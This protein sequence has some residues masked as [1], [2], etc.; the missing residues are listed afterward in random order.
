MHPGHMVVRGKQPRAETDLDSVFARIDADFGAHLGRIQDY[1]RVPSVSGTG[2][3]ID[4]TAAATAG[5]I[6]S[7]GGRAQIVSTP[8]HPVVI[9]S[10][11]GDGP[12]LLRYGMYDVQPADEADWTS[13]P[14]AAQVHDVPGVGPA[15]VAR[16]SANSKGC[17]IAFFLALESYKKEGDLPAD[18]RFIIDGEEEL[19]SPSLP[20]VLESHRDELAADAAFDLDLTADLGGTPEIFLGCK[21]ILSLRLH[22]RGGDWGGPTDRALHSSQGVVISSPA[23]SLVRALASLVDENEVPRIPALKA[24]P[25][26]PEDEPFLVE[27]EK[28]LDLDEHL[29]DA[30]ARRFKTEVDVPTLARELLYGV[31]VN[32][33]GIRTGYPDGGKTI[34]PHEA[35]AILDVRV[36]YGTDP[37]AVFESAK[38]VVAAV[39]PEVEV[40]VPEFCPPSRSS[41]KSA[42]GTAMIASHQA[43]DRPARVWP[44]APWWAP[45]HL[46]E[47]ELKLDFAVGGAGHGARAHASDEYASIDGLREHMKQSVAFLQAFAREHARA[48]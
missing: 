22:C 32:V 23:W 27:L 34:I 43:V 10:I 14:F 37:D 35:E 39:A 26:P 45:Y 9:G 18:L 4:R 11:P 46:F 38:E 19:G 42:V 20:A 29:R 3:G 31:A 5:L 17:L 30:G 48:K 16:G 36:P 28:I 33:N 8:G 7:V 47:R 15:I 41:A 21:G 6:Q 40:T 24:A 12:T 13:P 25:V 1:L 44:S 2:E